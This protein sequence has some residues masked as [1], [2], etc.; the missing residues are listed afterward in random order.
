MI[1][2]VI[3]RE[4]EAT[5][6]FILKE[7]RQSG[8]RMRPVL[9]NTPGSED[10]SLQLVSGDNMLLMQIARLRAENR[11]LLKKHDRMMGITYVLALMFV[12]FIAV[13]III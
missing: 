5:G 7:V 10:F 13:R 11:V 9:T 1:T 4:N 2:E 12:A 3:F 6:D 8:K